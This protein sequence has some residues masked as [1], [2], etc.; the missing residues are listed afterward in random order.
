MSLAPLVLSWSFCRGVATKKPKFK[1][2]GFFYFVLE[3]GDEGIGK[4][5]QSTFT[6]NEIYE[7]W[8]SVRHIV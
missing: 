3:E 1:D 7:K 8:S 2:F 5:F 4:N 6:R